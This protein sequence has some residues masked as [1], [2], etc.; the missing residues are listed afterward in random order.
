M[1]WSVRVMRK[2]VSVLTE[3]IARMDGVISIMA[4]IRSQ[5]RARSGFPMRPQDK[6]H[7]DA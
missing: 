4:R 3:V 1:R 6:Q 2:R 7:T 5:I